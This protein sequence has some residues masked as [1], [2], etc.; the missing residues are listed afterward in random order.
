[1]KENKELHIYMPIL[2]A[3]TQ[4]VSINKGIIDTSIYEQMKRSGEYAEV[5]EMLPQIF[6]IEDVRMENLWEE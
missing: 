4:E 2:I 5:V 6:Y 3:C 1:M